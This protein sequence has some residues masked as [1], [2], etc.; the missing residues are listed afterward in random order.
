MAHRMGNGARMLCEGAVIAAA[1]VGLTFVTPFSFGPVQLRVSE[2]LTLL[3]A[4]SAAAAPGLFV[5]CALANL[6]GGCTIWDV[7]FGS[8]ATLLAALLTRAFRRRLW[9][10]CLPPVVLNGLIVGAVLSLTS[11]GA[12]PLWAT[13]GFVALGEAG[14]VFL[15][16]PPVLRGVRRV[17]RGRGDAPR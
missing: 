7:A 16:A 5:G 12:L 2:A 15:L 17:L 8:L 13:I 4:V 14:A 9:L 1:Y 11:G 6:L 3:P 10:A